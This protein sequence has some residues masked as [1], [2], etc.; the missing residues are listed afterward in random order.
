MIPEK[1]EP[2]RTY[3]GLALHKCHIYIQY[4]MREKAMATKEIT[5]QR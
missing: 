3:P 4:N 2:T 5:E 1:P